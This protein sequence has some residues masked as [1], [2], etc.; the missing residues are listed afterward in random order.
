MEPPFK[1]AESSGRY[2]WTLEA[3]VFAEWHL[4]GRLSECEISYFYV[5]MCHGSPRARMCEIK[6]KV[7][8]VTHLG[9]VPMKMY[10]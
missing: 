8:H 2:L 3:G 7:A 4:R 9:G 6:S 10:F 1:M 5:F